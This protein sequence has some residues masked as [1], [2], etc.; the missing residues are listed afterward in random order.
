M[1]PVLL[2]A[3]LASSAVAQPR[4]E[5]SA[6]QAP[7]LRVDVV[8]SVGGALYA[9]DGDGRVL[10]TRD[11]ETRSSVALPNVRTN[12]RWKR[13]TVYDVAEG[14]DGRLFVATV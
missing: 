3:V 11:S 14:P 4:L 2:L 12:V 8:A 10:H 6:Q 13:P 7:R 9:G 1:R 5:W